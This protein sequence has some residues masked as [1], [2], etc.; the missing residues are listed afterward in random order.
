MLDDM[1]GFK[2]NDMNI[3]TPPPKAMKIQ[4]N[5]EFQ[6]IEKATKMGEAKGDGRASHLALE[7][8][9]GS[10]KKHDRSGSGK[11]PG[12]E[13]ENSMAMSRC[14]KETKELQ[15]TGSSSLCLNLE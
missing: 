11:R 5:K 12:C 10:P 2:V 6:C 14:E 8:S 3:T 9:K 1:W 13:R 7:V 15:G 4:S